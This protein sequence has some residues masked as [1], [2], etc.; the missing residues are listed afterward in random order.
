MEK[1]CI[2]CGAL[3]S[4]GEF[5]KNKEY[6]D[7]HTNKCKECVNRTQRETW[8]IKKEEFSTKRKERRLKKLDHYRQSESLR[9]KKWRD[10]NK[11]IINKKYRDYMKTYRAN[12]IQIRIS[13]C[14]SRA[15]KR[16]LI[17][18][19]SKNAIFNKLGYSLQDL[20]NHLEKKFVSGMSWENYGKWH[21]DHI[22]PQSWLPY[23]SIEDENFSKCWSL[24]NLQPLW[25]TDNISKGNRYAGSPDILRSTL[26]ICPD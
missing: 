7:G 20:M 11:E 18:K 10:D 8:D 26:M 23:N 22:I 1:T 24:S 15:F 25:A 6:K 12:N 2:K 14:V 9:L 17:I 19:H 5:A 13:K 3:K 16:G 4:I 21:I